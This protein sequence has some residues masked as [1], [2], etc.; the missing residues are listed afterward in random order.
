MN[1]YFLM[2]C[3]SFQLL[4]KQ[5]KILIVLFYYSIII[6]IIIIILLLLL[7]N[8]YFINR[9]FNYFNYFLWV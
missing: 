8:K 7:Y 9:E 5:K 2:I 4:V 3:L 6:I 1:D